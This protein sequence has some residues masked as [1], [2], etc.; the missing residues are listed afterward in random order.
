M[1]IDCAAHCSHLARNASWLAV[2]PVRRGLPRLSPFPD[3]PQTRLWPACLRRRPLLPYAAFSAAPHIRLAF[4]LCSVASFP[5]SL[6]PRRG[7]PAPM[8]AGLVFASRSGRRHHLFFSS[9]CCGLPLQPDECLRPRRAKEFRPRVRDAFVSP[10][11]DRP[12]CDAAKISDLPSPA[13]R[14]NDCAC[15]HVRHHRTCAAHP[16]GFF[17]LTNNA[18]IPFFSAL[19]LSHRH[20]STAQRKPGDSEGR[21]SGSGMAI[22]GRTDTTR[23]DAGEQ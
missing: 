3:G 22:G 16:Q 2:A 9:S 7:V 14:V 1:L 10:L 8:T 5:H 13:Q 17:V 11:R 21:Y 19:K 15:V 4:W 12:R 18:C 6:E 20:R 23:R